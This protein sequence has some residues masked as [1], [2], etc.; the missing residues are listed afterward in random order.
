MRE[1]ATAHVSESQEDC[2]YKIFILTYDSIHCKTSLALPLPSG[3]FTMPKARFHVGL[4]RTDGY[5][6][7]LL[8]GKNTFLHSYYANLR[9]G[10]NVLHRSARH[11]IYGFITFKANAHVI[12][13]VIQFLLCPQSCPCAFSEGLKH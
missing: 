3:I 12:K 11:K 9:R 7:I 10:R 4:C 8:V 1:K 6:Y 2:P 5:K 13:T